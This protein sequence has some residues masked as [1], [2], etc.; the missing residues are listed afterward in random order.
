[1]T[2]E[3]WLV[4]GTLLAL[5]FAALMSIIIRACKERSKSGHS[6]TDWR[7]IEPEI[8]TMHVRVVDLG[9]FVTHKGTKTPRVEENYVIAFEND[10]G[11]RCEFSVGR[12]MYDGF[13][14]G[15]VGE[16]TVIDGKVSS[17]VLDE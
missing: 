2:K 14:I 5:I 9:C 15:Q 1:M 13:E 3:S 17:Y 4:L 8:V 12:D 7:D 16:L 11:E 10:C 6:R